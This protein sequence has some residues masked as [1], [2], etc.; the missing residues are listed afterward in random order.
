[1]NDKEFTTRTRT[2][3]KEMRVLE[4]RQKELIKKDRYGGLSKTERDELE[5]LFED[6]TEQGSANIEEIATMIGLK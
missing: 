3:M 1:M 4:R 2:M 5:Q 6:M